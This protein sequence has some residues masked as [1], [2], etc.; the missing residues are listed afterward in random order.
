MGERQNRGYERVFLSQ[1]LRFGEGLSR[2]G[3]RSAFSY[4]RL[5]TRP[6]LKGATS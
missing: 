1:S 2:Q 6:S 3:Q 4:Q 5:A